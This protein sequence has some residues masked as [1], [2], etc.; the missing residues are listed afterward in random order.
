MT[1]HP[2][3]ATPSTRRRFSSIVFG[4]IA[5]V[6]AL[7]FAFYFYESLSQTLQLSSYLAAQN[8]R[9]TKVGHPQIPFPW[10]AIAPFL[11]LPFITYGVAFLFGRR[12]SVLVKIAVFFMALAVLSATSLT[13]ESVASQL[14]RIV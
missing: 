5:V 8:P 11:A 14:T 7:L 3:S 4:V 13:L 12:R 10:I 9:L 6:F 1:V 2:D